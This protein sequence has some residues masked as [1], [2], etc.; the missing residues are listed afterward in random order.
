[1][2]TTHGKSA[3]KDPD[4]YK[5]IVQHREKFNALR[6]LDYSNHIPSKIK[7]IPPREIIKEWEN[8][9]SILELVGKTDIIDESQ[10]SNEPDD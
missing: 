7:I 4:L 8:T 9:F 1:M 3:I 6:G 5:G 10:D 2:D